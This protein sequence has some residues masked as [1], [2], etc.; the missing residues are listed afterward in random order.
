MSS[1]LQSSSDY[2]CYYQQD[3]FLLCCLRVH[4]L[5]LDVAPFVRRLTDH[6]RGTRKQQGLWYALAIQD[7][8]KKKNY[9]RLT[10]IC[11]PSERMVPRVNEERQ[12]RRIRS[13]IASTL[14]SLPPCW[15]CITEEDSESPKGYL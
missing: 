9:H 2:A 5:R 1:S 12:K 13:D 6:T 3:W 15:S 8:I 10:F 14:G 7:K 4:G 11:L